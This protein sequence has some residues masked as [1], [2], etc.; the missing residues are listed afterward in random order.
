MITLE[1]TGTDARLMEID[2]GRVIRWASRS[3][4]PDIFEDQEVISDPRALGAE[5]KQLM[6]SSGIKGRNVTT[7]VSGLYSLSRIVLVPNP[8]GGPTSQMILEAAMEIMPV[9]EDEVYL[10]WQTIATVEDGQQTL[11]VSVPRDVIDNEMLALR[12]AGVNPRILDLRAMALARAVNREQ[13]LIFNIEHASFDIVIVV[14]SVVEIMRTIAWQQEGLSVEEKAE[15]LVIV[16]EQV[17]EFYN[18]QHRGSP[19]NPATPLFITGKMSG[20]GTLVDELQASL[21]YPIESL[22]P[23]LQY[24]EQLPVSLY[25]VNIGLALK[26]SVLARSIGQSDISLPDIN[27]L[28]QVYRPW[29]P[30]ARQIYFFLAIVTALGLL[31]PLYLSASESMAETDT[32]KHKYTAISDL[33]ELRRLELVKREPLQ[34]AIAEY[35][36]IVNMGGGFV[37]DLEVINGLAEKLGVE[38]QSITHSESSITFTCEADNYIIFREYITTLEESGRFTSIVTP[39][40][41]YP[42]PKGGAIKLEQKPAE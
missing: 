20:D 36:T 5:I 26:G 31:F 32:L 10:S 38:V 11:V 13:A 15:H 37:D 33:L 14:D 7:A 12:T 17:V 34:R 29:R 19:L 23:P 2:K 25:A 22:A 39:P 1:I 27:L 41:D 6:A 30:S 8:P 18:S 16:L 4:E 9:S 24:P 3:L 42:Y 21:K 35:N 28:P 40:E